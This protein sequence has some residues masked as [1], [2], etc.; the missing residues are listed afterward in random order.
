MAPELINLQGNAG[1]YFFRGDDIGPALLIFSTAFSGRK[2]RPGVAAGSSGVE[3][4]P[5]RAQSPKSQ[6]ASEQFVNHHF[7]QPLT[8]M[9]TGAFSGIILNFAQN[10]TMT[11]AKDLSSEYTLLYGIAEK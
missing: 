8:L 11:A 5:H 2:A 4:M 7:R 10:L 3:L 1:N 9:I 6:T